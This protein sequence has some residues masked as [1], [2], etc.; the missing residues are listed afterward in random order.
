MQ[1]KQDEIPYVFR[2]KICKNC[3]EEKNYSE[4]RTEKGPKPSA[5]CLVCI[6]EMV[7]KAYQQRNPKSTCTNIKHFNTGKSRMVII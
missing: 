7:A 6:K 5:R 3:G 2:K 1:Q 4:F